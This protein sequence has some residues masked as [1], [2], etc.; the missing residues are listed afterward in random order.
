MK[1]PGQSNSFSRRAKAMDGNSI[2]NQYVNKNYGV[3]R[4][5]KAH[6]YSIISTGTGKYYGSKAIMETFKE[7]LIRT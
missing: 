6:K 2:P 5:A 1:G 4:K 3:K 7:F